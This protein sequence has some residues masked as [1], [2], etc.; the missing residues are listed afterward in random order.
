MMLLSVSSISSAIS[1]DSMINTIARQCEYSG[2]SDC[3]LVYA[4]C[5]AESSLRPRE[6]GDKKKK[7][8][9][10]GLCQLQ[11]RTGKDRDRSINKDRLLDPDTNVAIAIKHLIWLGRTFKTKRT[12]IDGYNR[13]RGN[14]LKSKRKGQTKHVRKVM[15]YYKNKLI[16]K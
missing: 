16:Y 2:Y 11:E 6:I 13:G 1:K 15:I 7:H 10:Y 3:K 9:A 4:I 8:K 14:V 5:R 12:I